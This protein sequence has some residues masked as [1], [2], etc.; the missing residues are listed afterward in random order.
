MR[1]QSIEL[2][3]FRQFQNEKI[4]FATGKIK[5]VTLIMGDNGAGKTSLAQA[6][7]WCLYGTVSFQDKV[8]L[9]R[10]KLNYLTP[11]KSATVV[12]RLFL[13]HNQRHYTIIRS[14]EY[15]MGNKDVTVKNSEINIKVTD[16]H[17]NTSWVGSNKSNPLARAQAIESEINDILPKEL[18][19]YFFF[20]GEKIE[21]LSK[22]ISSGKKAI[23][24]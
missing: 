3:N 5:N 17:G 24:S 20:D 22:E 11:G 1:I 12:V 8:L 6:F 14:Q 23:A 7:F 16:I 9:N 21:S 15:Y 18:S 19:R 4:E 2:E 10:N 13:D